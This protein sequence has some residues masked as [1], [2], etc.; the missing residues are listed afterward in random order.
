M[1]LCPGLIEIRSVTSEIRCRKKKE[2]RKKKKEKTTAVKYNPFG[3]AMP[4][5]L[6]N[7]GYSAVY[8][9]HPPFRRTGSRLVYCE[10]H[11]LYV[12]KCEVITGPST[13][14]SS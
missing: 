5:G 6:I 13:S 4:C 12:K 8:V 10:S 7:A 14:S 11:C 2:R 1:N 9:V 3:I